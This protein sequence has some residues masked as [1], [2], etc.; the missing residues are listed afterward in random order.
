MSI[1]QIKNISRSDKSMIIAVISDFYLSHSDYIM[2]INNTIA[3][4]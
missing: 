4:R 1:E 3:T 2:V